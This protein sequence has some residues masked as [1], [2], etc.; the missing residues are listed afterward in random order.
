MKHIW[1][2]YNKIPNKYSKTLKRIPLQSKSDAL[3]WNK[4]TILVSPR[5]DVGIS[6]ISCQS[7]NPNIVRCF[8]VNKGYFY[9]KKKNS[10]GVLN[11]TYIL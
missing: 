3:F 5:D 1:N 9:L 4:P 7:S 8:T 10:E 6:V 11:I 2:I